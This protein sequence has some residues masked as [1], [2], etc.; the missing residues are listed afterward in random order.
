MLYLDRKIGERILIGENIEIELVDVRN[1]G[2]S[3]RLGIDAP[4]DVPVHRLEVFRAIKAGE[5]RRAARRFN[6]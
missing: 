3:A 1:S 5:N 6:K 4:I 2:T